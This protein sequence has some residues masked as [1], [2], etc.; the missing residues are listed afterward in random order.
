MNPSSPESFEHFMARALHDPGK[1]YYRQGVATVGRGGDFS[2]SATLFP[3]L[4]RAIAFWLREKAAFMD[5]GKPVHVI[6]TGGGT[7]ALM[8]SI[9]QN[10]GW[11]RRRKFRF[12]SVESSLPLKKEQEK[13]LSA[14]GVQWHPE[15]SDALQACSGQAL[16]YSNELV[17]AFP[18]AVLGFQG[19]QWKELVLRWKGKDA[20][21]EWG[22]V[23]EPGRQRM[24]KEF[25]GFCLHPRP[26]Q[27]VEIPWS[28]REWMASWLPHWKQ[29]N[30]LTIDY[31]DSAEELLRLHRYG[32]LRAY[33][34][35]MRLEGEEIYR[36]V[37][38]QD[39][40]FD[41]NFSLLQKWG[42]ELGLK[43][44][45]C[46]SQLEFLQKWGV[47]PDPDSRAGQAQ[48]MFR[49]LEQHRCSS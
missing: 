32:T 46:Q 47:A 43:T 2:T 45:S 23:L 18:C 5:K 13:R 36:R 38:E 21:E 8:L 16:L 27:R 15:M 48:G 44:L 33:F 34:R 26:G 49:I 25:S 42:E 28:Y 3:V 40:T 4:G 41:V 10:L 14:Y 37:G 17:D 31:G 20:V 35:H 22:G 39:I 6:E 9:L 12:H 24:V 1:G 30:V 7:G 11:W 19:N 29:G